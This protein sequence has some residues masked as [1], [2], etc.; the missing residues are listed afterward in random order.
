MDLFEYAN[1][2]KVSSHASAKT[3]DTIY[4]VSQATLE[5]KRVLAKHFLS[6][7]PLLIQGEVANF[8]GRNSSKHMYFSLKDEG[9]I[10]PCVFFKYANAKCKVAIKEGDQ[11]QLKGKIEVYEKG[12]RYQLIVDDLKPKGQGVLYERFV[13]LKQKLEGEGLFEQAHKQALPALPKRI[14]VV[15]SATGAVI[16]DI[17]HVIKHRAPVVDIVLFPCKVQGEGAHLQIMEQVKR[18]QDPQFKIDVL[19]VGRGGGSM[20]DLWCFNDEA[21][22]RVIF[23]SKIPVISAVGHQ[24]D[25]TICDFVSDLRAATPS[26]A[27]EWVVPDLAQVQEE[28][29]QRMASIYRLALG[30]VQ[31]KAM[32]LERLQS[33]SVM[34]DPRSGLNQSLQV[35]DDLKT[36]I[37]EQAK[38]VLPLKVQKRQFLTQRF[39]SQYETHIAL[40]RQALT[41]L[42][43][44]LEVLNPQN[45]LARGY[46]IVKTKNKKIISQ[47]SQVQ[48]KDELEVT[49]SD[50]GFECLVTKI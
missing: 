46:S 19:I 9:A 27:A 40:R 20:E 10:M 39:F 2:G 30:G 11:V 3:A 45:I 38:H 16:K 15:T 22:A 14:G 4:T 29:R 50:G 32:E 41:R 31:R 23:S 12:G 44:K 24:T 13:K 43:E 21:L 25:F 37:I 47:F 34:R 42:T 28:T 5:I 7:Q 48:I 6:K 26:H 36:R 1:Q 18:A 35:L 17:I 33:S 8:R 49:L